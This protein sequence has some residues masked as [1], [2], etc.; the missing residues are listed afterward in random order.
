MKKVIVLLCLTI[1][2]TRLL[3]WFFLTVLLI[4]VSTLTHA[5]G[6]PQGQPVEGNSTNVLAS[7]PIFIDATQFPAATPCTQ[8]INAIA[9]VPTALS[10]IGG[11]DI[12]A[13]G[14]GNNV[15]FSGA[16]NPG[17]GVLDSNFMKNTAT[18]MVTTGTSGNAIK[19]GTV[20]LGGYTLQVSLVPSELGACAPGAGIVC[21]TGPQFP[22]GAVI[23]IPNKV[24]GLEGI[25]RGD[26][27]LLNTNIELCTGNNAPASGCKAPVQRNWSISGITASTAGGR[28]YMAVTVTANSSNT[29]TSGN[30]DIVG[31]GTLGTATLADYLASGQL[32]SGQTVSISG[33]TFGSTAVLFGLPMSMAR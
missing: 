14:I 10:A 8:I 21:A 17:C 6:Y 25:G 27:G 12:D 15:T 33:G 11:T 3:T 5:Q 7:S 26:A 16:T 31:N 13:R 24:R 23:L 29:N 19:G 20:H 22:P 28:N 32:S 9:A 2:G 4:A 1:V 30:V 18:A